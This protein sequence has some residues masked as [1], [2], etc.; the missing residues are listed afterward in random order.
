M[1]RLR[2]P[3]YASDEVEVQGEAV[4][5]SGLA[6]VPVSDGTGTGLGAGTTVAEA[7]VLPVLGEQERAADIVHGVRSASGVPLDSREASAKGSGRGGAGVSKE[8]GEW[9]AQSCEGTE[10]GARCGLGEEEVVGS[11]AAQPPPDGVPTTSP[12]LSL[13]P[14]DI[15]LDEGIAEGTGWDSDE[16]GKEAAKGGTPPGEA[17]ALSVTS[18]ESQSGEE[19]G[20]RATVGALGQQNEGP[21]GVDSPGT[22][23]AVTG[24][25][26]AHAADPVSPG[27]SGACPSSPR[28]FVKGRCL[29]RVLEPVREH[30]LPPRPPG[31]QVGAQAR[32][33]TQAEVQ[34][35]IQGQTADGTKA[36][37]Q[38]G[39][40]MGALAL[41]MTL[42]LAS[43]PGGVDLDSGFVNVTGQMS[44]NG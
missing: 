29:T 9:A 36:V 28:R 12:R 7:S 10:V 14:R 3:G 19:G 26:P 5:P 40:E 24:D 30:R 16:D 25:S 15:S 1:P 34:A 44:W 23:E 31:A 37:S 41:A 18:V 4:P 11:G 17:Q 39:S 13:F 33:G 43:V 27:P 20:T 2:Y 6:G 38:P 21:N 35:V 8:A 32:A 42:P 22:A